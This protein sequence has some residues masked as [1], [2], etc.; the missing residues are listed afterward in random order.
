MNPLN[1]LFAD[2]P[3]RLPGEQVDVLVEGPGVRIERVISAGQVSPDGFWFDQRRA[4]WVAVLTGEAKLLF[5][6]DD[7]PVVMTPGDHILIP[8]HRRH[9]VEWTTPNEPT[10]WLAVFF[11]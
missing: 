9:R 7:E 2:L 3:I 6:G 5:E 10:V 4:E 1:N 11:A 8:A